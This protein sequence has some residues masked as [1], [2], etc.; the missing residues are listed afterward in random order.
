MKPTWNTA[1]DWAQYL[2]MDEDGV[3]TW[4]MN[5]PIPKAG[6]WASV[7]NELSVTRPHK[8]WKQT[9]EPRPTEDNHE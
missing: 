5:R 2:A 9:L 3:W 6:F 7:G 4:Y 1:P 8:H